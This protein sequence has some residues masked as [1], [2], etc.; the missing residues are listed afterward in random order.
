MLKQNSVQAIIL[1]GATILIISLLAGAIS[2]T[3]QK[4][5]NKADSKPM[6]L[7]GVQVTVASKSST[8][9]HEAAHTVQQGRE[10]KPQSVVTD[11]DGSFDLGVLPAGTYGLTLTMS[12]AA[13]VR[14]NDI[15]IKQNIKRSAG[16]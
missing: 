4:P 16:G 5:I 13:R 7:V 11:A 8:N 12:E 2:L 9:A 1:S 3:T 14:N 15:Y 6:G 10:A